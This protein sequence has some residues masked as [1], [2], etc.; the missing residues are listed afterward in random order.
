MGHAGA[1]RWSAWLLVATAA[2]ASGRARAQDDNGDAQKRAA[3]ITQ[4]NA[5]ATDLAGRIPGDLGGALSKNGDIK[6]ALDQLDAVKGDDTAASDIVSHWRDYVAR[7]PD[8]A[9]ALQQLLTAQDR[10]KELDSTCQGQDA[11]LR[12][13]LKKYVD[14]KNTNGI[15]EI[16]PLADSALAP[17]K[18]T[19]D[20]AEAANGTLS[21]ARDSAGGFDGDG[22]WATVRDGLTRA[23]HDA[24][25]RWD[26]NRQDYT[27]SC[28]PLLQPS[29]HPAVVETLKFLT[30]L[31]TTRDG[32]IDS[33]RMQ[34]R[35]VATGVADAASQ[36]DDNIIAGTEARANLIQN[37]LADLEPLEG[38][39][40]TANQLA[41]RWP[42]ILKDYLNAESALRQLKQYQHTLDSGT[43][44][45]NSAG[46]QLQ[47]EISNALQNAGDP[48]G[49]ANT[50]I[51]D[52]KNI[53]APIVSSLSQADASRATVQ[54]ARDAVKA[55]APDDDSWKE[56]AAALAG[57]ADAL[58]QYWENMLAQAH[59]TCDVV[60][61][62]DGNPDIVAAL[63]ILTQTGQDAFKGFVALADRWI[64][65]ARACYRVDCDGMTSIW[66]AFCGDDWEDGDDP[67]KDGARSAANDIRSK[68]QS[69][70]DPVLSRFASVDAAA[71]VPLNNP[72]TRDDA[73]R[74]Y[75]ELKAVQAKLQSLPQSGAYRGADH[76]LVQHAIEY[77]KQQHGSM[78]SSFN[79]DVY[80]KRFGSDDERPDCI[81]FSDCAIYEFKPDNQRARDKGFDQLRGY[82]ES[83]TRYYQ[84][85]ID[86]G[87]SADSD[88]G[89]SDAL[90]KLA[91]CIGDDKKI[92]FKTDVK[93]YN[94]CENEYQC[95]E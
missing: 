95:A 88:H 73:Q 2:A 62:G 38:T 53:A 72:D 32:L 48:K 86:S 55:F 8:G 28:T 78:S 17:V 67:D 49:A 47:N 35:G 34:V 63:G 36:S 52:S 77:G 75:D 66:T 24:W 15:T 46:R 31:K 81:V 22:P 50:L 11:A 74:K 65:D 57:S 89:G 64:A 42:Q 93:T 92:T 85:L 4:L 1:R 27:R 51:L 43:D 59:S 30:D 10:Y 39:D 26:R 16:P 68:M 14:D 7:F 84:G 71:Q 40:P 9:N 5:L 91:G 19:V 41:S 29:S 21:S 76:P 80:D 25:A 37:G 44:T 79:C 69:L 82:L 58:E 54:K 94:M 6:S 33:L 18:T 83:V 60:A 87:D 56:V 13:Q 12:A 90:Q 70:I 45:C 20:E 3:L 61:K 23:A